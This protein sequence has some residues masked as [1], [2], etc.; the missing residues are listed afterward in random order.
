MSDQDTWLRRRRGRLQD[1]PVGA[2]TRRL[3]AGQQAI[4][5]HGEIGGFNLDYPRLTA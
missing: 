5:V 4:T 3:P 2:R 1:V